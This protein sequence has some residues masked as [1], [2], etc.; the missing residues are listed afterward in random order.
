MKTLFRRI[1]L[2]VPLAVLAAACATGCLR[3]C[4]T[5]PPPPEY[6]TGVHEDATAGRLD[7]LP[8]R[9]AANPGVDFRV[10]LLPD[11]GIGWRGDP[12]LVLLRGALLRARRIRPEDYPD[13][14]EIS[15]LEW[16]E[17]GYWTNGVYATQWTTVSKILTQ[18]GLENNRTFSFSNDDFYGSTTVLVARVHSPDGT[19]RD[20]DLAAN[21]AEA[22]DTGSLASNI[23]DPNEKTFTLALPGLQVGDTVELSMRRIARKPRC[24][25]VFADYLTFESDH[26][27]LLQVVRITG[28]ASMP[29]RSR[30]F[31]D[32]GPVSLEHAAHTNEMFGTI[33]EVWLAGETPRYFAEPN[34]PPAYDCTARLL[35]S[36]A[37]DW[38]S[39]SR[40]YARLCAPHLAATNEAMA[41][42]VAEIVASATSS[43]DSDQGENARSGTG[44]RKY[45]SEEERTAAV[46]A[47]LDRI[48][49]EEIDFEEGSLSDVITFL[50]CYA[51]KFQ[52]AHSDVMKHGIGFTLDAGEDNEPDNAALRISPITIKAKNASLRQLLDTV[53]DMA[54]LEYR[55]KHG[56]VAIRPAH[57]RA[58]ELRKPANAGEAGFERAQSTPGTPAKP[59][60][61]GGE[62]A[63]RTRA[64]VVRALFDFVSREVRY[65]GAMAESEAP[66]YEPHD[67]SLTFDN[68][69]GVCRDKA[70]LLVAMLRMAGIDAWPVL[71]NV[72]PRK[73]PDVPQPY[74]NHAIVA[75]D[76]GDP[77]DPYLLMDPTSETTRS[78]LPEYL[79][80]MSYLVAR[81]EGEG[82]RET[83]PLPVEENLLR[84]ETVYTLHGDASAD[85]TTTLTFL[86]VNDAAY[87]QYFASRPR[88]D[89]RAFFERVLAGVPGAVLTGWELRPAQEE[90]R[91]SPEPLVARIDYAIA[92]AAREA[93]G[94]RTALLDPP[95][96][97]AEFA[98]ASRVVG[99]LGLEKRRFPLVTDYPCGFEETVEFRLPPGV[100]P[101]RNPNP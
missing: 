55:I 9:L 19:R 28:P 48:I 7:D 60:S 47:M 15:L 100:T 31:R 67:V 24:E 27:S 34:M 86:G 30:A 65:M 50:A 36:T 22:I 1:R 13:A 62:A 58:E 70:A 63:L 80:E 61:N 29:L 23:H 20:V 51:Q 97:A 25:G 41:L 56:C 18:R 79:C 17:T 59:P 85:V 83:P 54:G 52:S 11:A 43:A 92:E 99:D 49:V 101:T 88:D 53:V 74:F 57:P 89:V 78:L 66:G 10:D 39:L 84:A 76:S 94:G 5:D 90:L 4:S 46:L 40:W 72:G 81:E 87:R 35:L 98:I 44:I 37:P 32:A 69:Y 68:R 12:D 73:D 42:K 33:T 71:I 45:P 93:E 91:T 16:E 8:R 14:D 2:P 77:D 3:T 95:S 6:F 96:L 82:I 21:L 75:A 64:S 26:P 38:E